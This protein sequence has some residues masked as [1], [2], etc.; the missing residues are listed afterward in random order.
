MACTDCYNGCVET[1][2]DTCIKYTGVSIPLLEIVRG[3]S[4]LIVENKL[5]TFLLSAL[6]GTGIVP[7]INPASLCALISSF[8]P[9]SGTI[10]LVNIVDALNKSICSLQTQITATNENITTI[11]NIL[12]TLNANYT[13]GCLTGVTASSDT[14]D[15]VQAAI[16]KLCS[17]SS[18]LDALTLNVSTNYISISNIDSYIAAY[19]AA[20]P[21]STY[22]YS[23]M[24]PNTAIPYF[25]S[26]SYFDG[27]GKGTGTWDKIYLCN[28]NNST[29][30]MRGRVPVGTTTQMLGGVFDAQVNPGISGNPEYTIGTKG[31]TN[32][33]VLDVTQIPSHTHTAVTTIIDPGH[34]HTTAIGGYED[35]NTSGNTR[36]WIQSGN[37]TTL[38]TNMAVTGIT[39]SV[40]NTPIGQDLSH[41]NIQPVLATHYIIYIP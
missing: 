8:L 39:A 35:A 22:E 6:D 38:P 29:P 3:D 18:D 15:I 16:T 34:S 19:L 28:G 9:V 11:S 37:T 41:S 17:V 10:S 26:L 40:V 4:L 13:I 14:H 33:I 12:T 31:G 25:G 5:S 2:S 32:N 23:K 24:V 21:S 20:H 27:T 7:Y 36:T 1:V 30:D